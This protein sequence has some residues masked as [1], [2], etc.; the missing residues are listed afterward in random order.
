[1]WQAIDNQG[2]WQGEIWNRRKNGEIYPEWLAINAVRNPLS[3]ITHYV[4][5]FS[6]LTE[7][8]AAD[9]RIQFLAHF[10]VL[11]SLPNRAA[12]PGELAII[13]PAAITSRWPCCCWTWTASR[14]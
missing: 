11:T 4:A 8:K 12:R 1:M 2:S 13:M 9:E 7:R 14:P 3:E 5:I 6:D 10:D